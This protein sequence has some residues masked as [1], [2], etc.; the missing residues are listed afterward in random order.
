MHS[1]FNAARDADTHFLQI[2]ILPSQQGID[3]G[4][5]QKAFAEAD[6]RGRLRLLASPEGRDGSLTVHADASLY[7][8]LFDGDELATLALPPGRLGYVH[9]A[10]G[11]LQVNGQALTAGDAVLLRGE[12]QVSLAH[13]RDADVLVFDLEP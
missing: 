13:G 5:E 4:Y 10:R 2:W 7:A 6:K 12:P 1:E 11:A 8:G 9:V 3:P